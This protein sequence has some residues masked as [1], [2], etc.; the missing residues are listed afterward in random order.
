MNIHYVFVACFMLSSKQLCFEFGFD[1]YL[2]LIFIPGARTFVVLSRFQIVTYY[3]S[4]WLIWATV[5]PGI[6][7]P[8]N[9]PL[10][11]VIPNFRKIRRRRRSWLWPDY[12]L[13]WGRASMLGHVAWCFILVTILQQKLGWLELSKGRFLVTWVDIADI[14]ELLQ[15]YFLDFFSAWVLW[16][17]TSFLDD[18]RSVRT[19]LLLSY[20]EV[21]FRFSNSVWLWLV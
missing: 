3:L 6:S 20:L 8:V 1:N 15:V 17:K 7:Q 19:L 14:T 12:S 18:L 11:R 16:S 4:K 13:I 9:M 5:Y 21:V 10:L 2:I